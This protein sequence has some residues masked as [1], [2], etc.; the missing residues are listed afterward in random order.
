MSAI[1]SA[2]PKIIKR[3]KKYIPKRYTKN[4]KNTTDYKRISGDPNKNPL[5]I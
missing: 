4:T 2:K 1:S 3:K 5:K